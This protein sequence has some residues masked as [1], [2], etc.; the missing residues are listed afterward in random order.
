M[1]KGVLIFVIVF[2]CILILNFVLIR[3]SNLPIEKRDKTRKI[4]RYLNGLFFIMSGTTNLFEKNE[5][6][7]I[8]LSQII[9]GSITI[10]LIMLGKMGVKNLQQ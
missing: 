10:V 3:F 8:S 6:S 4:F 1:A 5:F 7:F 9:L 2:T